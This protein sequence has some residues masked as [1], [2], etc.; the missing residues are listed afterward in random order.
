MSSAA[1]RVQTASRVSPV[2]IRTPPAL[3]AI[4]KKFAPV[5]LQ[6]NDVPVPPANSDYFGRM[7]LP[8]NIE[9]DS[10]NYS[11]IDVQPDFR[12]ILNYIMYH[13]TNLAP[14]LNFKGHPYFSP[15]SYIGYCL[16]MVF[17]H[18]FACDATF[19]SEKS[20][21][22]ARFITDAE[23]NDLYST[24]LN[25]HIP[26]WLSDLLLEI[27]PVYDPRRNNLQ[28]VPTLAAHSF[29]HDFGRTPLP[30][31]FYAAHHLLAST[32]TNK[33]PDDVLDDCMGLNVI[34][35]GTTTYKV[36]NY[37]GTWYATGHH[38]NWLN[39][40]FLSFFNPLVGRF[41]TQRPTF[42]RMHFETENMPVN[43]TGSP[44]IAYLLASDE[45]T[46]L[47][48]HVLDALSQ[49]TVAN[50]PR[51]PKLGSVL[52]SVSGTLLLS[53]SIEPP[54]L[55]TWTG[56]TY[57]QDSSPGDVNDVTFAAD[58]H[59]LVDEQTHSQSLPFP[60]STQD[61]LTKWLHNMKKK[62]NKD[63]TPFKHLLFDA[64]KHLTPY[65]LYFQPYDVSPSS[66]GLTIA[67]GLKIEHG[68]IAAFGINIEQPE[69]SLDDNNSQI[70]NSAIRLDKIARVNLNAVAENNRTAVLIRDPLDRTKQGV[71]IAFRSM[72]KV[73]FPTLDNEAVNASASTT[74]N[75]IGLTS[76]EGHYNFDLAFNVKA[77][78]QGQI[79]T[80]AHSIYLWSSYRYVHKKKNP[81]PSDI[82]ML[83]TL[84]PFYGVNVTLSRSKNPVLIVP[85]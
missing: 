12:F 42:A 31:M 50:E 35:A 13:V 40:D 4:A 56:A 20:W 66:I 64:S 36:S 9:L 70:L 65:V 14:E 16:Q 46:S 78:T 82:S 6:D 83:A 26:T 37:L 68:D 54:T 53:Y 23:R 58:H 41:L 5:V 49:F 25:A 59:F 24:A 72:F 22:A 30:A 73:I 17:W 67:A 63:R 2:E 18:L 33:D 27:S 29:E 34:T 57:S 75:D 77:G 76:E 44:Y 55:P 10:G 60:A 1:A 43:G 15:L 69:S 47:M 38:D 51:A 52:A 8:T 48:T 19:R 39:R 3:A 7:N 11:T 85:H 32:R 21:H 81:A 28:F 80:T 74:P 62:H 61:L 71:M 45:N 84:R 79:T